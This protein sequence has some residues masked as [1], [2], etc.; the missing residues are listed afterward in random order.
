MVNFTV[1]V[2]PMAGTSFRQ[3]PPISTNPAMTSSGTRGPNF[4]DLHQRLLSNRILRCIERI[5]L[6]GG[7]LDSEA[8]VLMPGKWVWRFTI[9]LTVLDDGGNILDA[10]VLAAMASLRHYRKP[11]VDFSGDD[12]QDSSAADSA[13]AVLPT[14]IPSTSKEPT[15][16]P[17]HHT[18]LSISFALIPADDAVNSASSTSTVAALVDPTDREELVQNGNLTIAMNVHSEMC[19]LDYGGGCELLPSKLK[20]CWKIAQSAVQELCQLLEVALK[21]ADDQA[22]K[23]QLLQL[24]RQRYGHDFDNGASMKQPEGSTPYFQQTDENDDLMDVEPSVNTNQIQEAEAEAEEA[25]RAQALDYAQGHFASAVREDNPK[26]RKASGFQQQAG[27]LLA[28]MLKSVSEETAAATTDSSSK[29]QSKD[30]DTPAD[31]KAMATNSEKPPMIVDDAKQVPIGKEK[32]PDKMPS[33]SNPAPMSMDSDDEEEAPTV[34]QSEFQPAARAAKPAEQQPPAAPTPA[35][36]EADIT[37]LSMA[38]KTKKKKSK[39]K[40]K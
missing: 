38:I 6:V 31:A 21:E 14:M 18:P 19:L 7:A 11:Q 27:S 17:L 4:S 39:S 16:L 22:Q 37:D 28:A 3:A 1:D 40:R 35:E 10:C 33:K 23:E 5:I 15:P 25:Y 24:Q 8:L 12:M 36:S 29:R 32:G 20:E 30:Q 2:S 34:L 26:D 9:A 13:S